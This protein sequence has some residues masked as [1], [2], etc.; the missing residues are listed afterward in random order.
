MPVVVVAAADI[1]PA[2][3]KCLTQFVQVAANRPKFHFS[4]L[5]R[6]QFIALTVLNSKEGDNGRI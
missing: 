1:H 2:H 6:N 4:H 3:A 5:V